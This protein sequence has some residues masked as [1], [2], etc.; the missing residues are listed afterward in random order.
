MSNW[1]K[2]GFCLE[3]QLNNR[4]KVNLPIEMHW[5]SLPLALDNSG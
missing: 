3:L 5:G 1:K 4:A 2:S